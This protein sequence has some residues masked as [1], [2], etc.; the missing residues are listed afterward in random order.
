M[1]GGPS[2]EVPCRSNALYMTLEGDAMYEA[3]RRRPLPDSTDWVI[4]SLRV[5]FFR[6]GEFA[7][8]PDL[9]PLVF[10]ICAAQ[11]APVWGPSEVGDWLE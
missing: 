3:H 2:K 6:R 8:L 5:P 4:L 9:W 10:I 11:F 1:A 7:T